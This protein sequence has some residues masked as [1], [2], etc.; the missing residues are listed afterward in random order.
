MNIVPHLKSIKVDLS[1]HIDSYEIP[2]DITELETIAKK[3]G[4]KDKMSNFFNQFDQLKNEETSI[5]EIIK[6][7]YNTKIINIIDDLKQE[8]G[9]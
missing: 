3:I 9:E 5:K 6:A 8:L 1:L 7:Y 4:K 2:I